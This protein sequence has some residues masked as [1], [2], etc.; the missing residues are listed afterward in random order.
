VPELGSIETTASQPIGRQLAHIS[1]L[2]L[3]ALVI[4]TA[5]GILLVEMLLQIQIDNFLEDPESPTQQGDRILRQQLTTA[6]D[7]VQLASFIIPAF[8]AFFGFYVVRGDMRDAIAGSFF[9]AFIVIL[10]QGMLFNL[11]LSETAKSDLRGDLVE[12]FID[13]LGTVILFYFG[14]EAI[15][16]S[17]RQYSLTRTEARGD[18]RPVT[19]EVDPASRG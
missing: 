4:A 2:R 19:T 10:T 1:V 3:G 8:V 13:L 7:Y 11:G 6:A 5:F 17:A 9:V 18:G 16:Q 14:S 12:A 15:I